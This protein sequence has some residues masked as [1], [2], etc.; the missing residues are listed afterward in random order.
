MRSPGSLLFLSI[1]LPILLLSFPRSILALPSLNIENFIRNGS[2]ESLSDLSACATQ[3]GSTWTQ[4]PPSIA[5]QMMPWQQVRNVDVLSPPNVTCSDGIRCLDLN[6]GTAA[7]A[8]L[9]QSFFL[10]TGLQYRLLIDFGTRYTHTLLCHFV[11]YL[12]NCCLVPYS[13]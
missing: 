6:V 7:T 13:C 4:C 11:N 9:S 10:T 5:S 2:F 3:A 8:I 12:T 1:L